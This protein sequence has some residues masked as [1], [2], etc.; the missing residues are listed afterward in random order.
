M[1]DHGRGLDGR[2]VARGRHRR[3]AAGWNRRLRRR[4]GRGL[5]GTQAQ[6]R[7]G[8]RMGGQ[9]GKPTAQI[10]QTFL[11]HIDNSM[12]HLVELSLLQI[13]GRVGP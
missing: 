6:A 9:T 3:Q 7:L 12:S 4:Q 10:K 11:A 5:R 1:G 8:R 13:T 2:T